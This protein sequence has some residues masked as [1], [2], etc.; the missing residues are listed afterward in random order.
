M[1]FDISSQ[2]LIVQN[3]IDKVKKTIV[4][5]G[6]VKNRK[7]NEVFYSFYENVRKPWV[8]IKRGYGWRMRKYG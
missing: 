7:L 6:H 4:R 2:S 3:H 5:T 8:G 1:V